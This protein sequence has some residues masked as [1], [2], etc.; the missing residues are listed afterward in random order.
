MTD[1]PSRNLVTGFGAR[2]LGK[3]IALAIA[4]AERDELR[5]L[6][7]VLDAFGDRVQ[8][9][10]RRQPDDRARQRRVAAVLR[11]LRDE[12]PVD[13]QNV[14]RETLQIAEIRSSRCRSRR[15]RDARR[16]P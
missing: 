10:C 11:N 6:I 7:G 14:D 1:V 12:R 13:L 9:E 15:S 3:Q 16:A 5:A 8:L 2:G 4:A